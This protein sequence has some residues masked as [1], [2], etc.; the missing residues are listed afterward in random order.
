MCININFFLLVLLYFVGFFRVTKL[1][2]KKKIGNSHKDID[3]DFLL[4]YELIKEK[5]NSK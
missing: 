3:H 5:K 4:E 1:F 2:E